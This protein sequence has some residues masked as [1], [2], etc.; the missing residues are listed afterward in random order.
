MTDATAPRTSAHTPAAEHLLVAPNE[1]RLGSI[2]LVL[3]LP[4]TPAP[5]FTSSGTCHRRRS[6]SPR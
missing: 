3:G 4:R 6:R 1:R 2:T 5:P